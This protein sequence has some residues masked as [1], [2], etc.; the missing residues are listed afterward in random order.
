MNRL[1]YRREAIMLYA[2][3]GQ[4]FFS[5]GRRVAGTLCDPA[6]L[7]PRSGCDLATLQPR[8]GCDPATLQSRSDC[9]PATPTSRA[10]AATL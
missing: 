10:A 8:S 6:T 4:W 7:Q 5:E 3:C 2:I 1:S 9:E